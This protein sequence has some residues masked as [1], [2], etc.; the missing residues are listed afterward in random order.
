MKYTKYTI[1]FIL[2]LS[3]F[4]SCKDDEKDVEPIVEEERFPVYESNIR[5]AQ[6]QPNGDYELKYENLLSPE[7]N[8]L[9]S[10]SG[11]VGGIKNP[12]LIY[13]VEGRK[14]SQALFVFNKNGE[15]QGK[16]NLGNTPNTDW[17]DLA[18]G[19]GPVDGESYI[20]IGDIGNKDNL[21]IHRFVEPN[22]SGQ[23]ENFEI[24]AQN[25]ETIPFTVGNDPRDCQSL[26]I[27]PKTKDLIVMAT[28][29]AF[30]Y[31]IPF[32]QSTTSNNE[33]FNQGLHR[34]RRE[35]IA[36]DISHDGKKML[37]KDV[38]EIF[39][40]EIPEGEDPV[41]V[42]FEGIP[43]KPIYKSEITG[44]S[45]GWTADGEYFTITDTDKR[46]GDVRRGEPILYGYEKK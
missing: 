1:L 7:E 21:S 41:K 19:P 3:I 36:A 8:Q 9:E 14:T 5:Y 45:M 26:M 20:Y 28:F 17:Q 39:L 44:A 25:V 40:W 43:S 46:G 6:A 12:D 18:I 22:L 33:A 10:S 38:G 42:L 35:I 30:V 29:Q 4:N 2:L 31:R 34:L 13:I 24:E 23:P 27:D 11:L 15:Y 16:I 37:I 32:P